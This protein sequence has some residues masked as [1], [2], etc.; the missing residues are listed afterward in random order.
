MIP[1]KTN[2]SRKGTTVAELH[3]TNVSGASNNSG[4]VANRNQDGTSQNRISNEGHVGHFQSGYASQARFIFPQDL[5]HFDGHHSNWERFN[6]ES[7]AQYLDMFGVDI[8]AADKPAAITPEINRLIYLCLVKGVD[9][10]SYNLIRRHVNEGFEAYQFLDRFIMGNRDYRVMKVVNGQAN[11]TLE[12]GENLAEYTG[13]V[14]ILVSEGEKYG[15]GE[16]KYKGTYPT[17]ITRSINNL[18]TRYNQ[19]AQITFSR[20]QQNGFP[21]MSKYLDELTEQDR[22]ITGQEN[23]LKSNSVNTISTTDTV[24]NIRSTTS[25]N[26]R[27]RLKAK[28]LAVNAA[29]ESVNLTRPTDTQKTGSSRGNGARGGRG[30]G[31]RGGRKSQGRSSDR[32]NTSSQGRAGPGSQQQQQQQFRKNISCTRCLSRDGTHDA[33]HCHATKYCKFHNNF[34]HWTNE[35]RNPPSKR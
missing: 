9:P 16:Q 8:L 2:N 34:S 30:R 18:P 15:V 1:R 22:I 21:S 11:L 27:R 28:R 33:D 5:V 4:T 10:K 31:A 26:Q 20:Y 35:C 17:L 19:W 25:R 24:N 29:L 3:N 32:E 6:F 12:D 14:T 7:Q 13:K 23:R